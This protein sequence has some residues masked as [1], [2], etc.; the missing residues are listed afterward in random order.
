MDDGTRDDRATH[1]ERWRN[2]EP[3]QDTCSLGFAI[4]MNVP[5]ALTTPALLLLAGCAQIVHVTPGT[6]VEVALARKPEVMRMPEAPAPAGVPGQAAPARSRTVYLP[7]VEPTLPTS[8][9]VTATA[10]AYTRGR[11]ALDEGRADDA[12][13]AFEQAVQLDPQF[14]DAW[15][16]LALAYEKVGKT[17]KAKAAF[18]HSKELAQH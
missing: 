3:G 16:S 2:I 8:D 14:T 17:D 7:P 4:F 11:A 13:A 1:V 10:E 15:Q 12:I 5:R 9:S 18:R 6:S